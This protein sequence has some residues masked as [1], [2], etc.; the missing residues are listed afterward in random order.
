MKAALHLARGIMKSEL[1]H[2]LK[3]YNCSILLDDD[4]IIVINKPSGLLVLPD[5][6]NK[7]LVNLYELLKGSLGNIYIVHRIDKETS[8]SIVCAKTAEA[9]AS[10]NAAFEERRVEK[11]YRAI[12]VGSPQND[13]GS[14][15]LP[16]ME[17]EH[18][19]R[20]MRVEKRNGK[21][22][23]TDYTVIER[24]SGHALVD[25]RPKT[26]RTHQIRLHL[27]AIGM[28]ILADPLYGDGKGFFL[29]SIKQNY[30]ESGPEKP[31]L[32]RTALHALSLALVHP[33]T[34][35]KLLLQAPM[36]KDM[37]VVLKVL[38]KYSM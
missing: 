8:G 31:L 7:S 36:P 2:I 4:A 6:F 11:I 28:P 23:H 14:I 33:V 32:S 18:G 9:H 25:A 27:S 16:I 35:Q 1:E 24:F 13:T 37:E 3:K 34:D 20:K 10:L 30:H 17:N 21:E 26:G 38:R 29:S 5:R 15:D 22:A 12:V 19:I